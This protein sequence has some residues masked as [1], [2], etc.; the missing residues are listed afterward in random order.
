[1]DC[2]CFYRHVV[3]GCT[4]LA[5]VKESDLIR[6]LFRQNPLKSAN[7]YIAVFISIGAL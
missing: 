7:S 5:D 3:C 4:E 1:M 6:L 2:Y